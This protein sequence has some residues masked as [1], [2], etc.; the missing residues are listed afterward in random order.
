MKLAS[1]WV[2]A[3]QCIVRASLHGVR[4]YRPESGIGARRY[5]LCDQPQ[6]WTHPEVGKCGLIAIEGRDGVA[7]HV[8]PGV[9]L[10]NGAG[11]AVL[12]FGL[13]AT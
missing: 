4:V 7:C 10:S 8:S 1:V 12:H 6:H 13:T 3:S 9:G 2:D 11:A 5:A